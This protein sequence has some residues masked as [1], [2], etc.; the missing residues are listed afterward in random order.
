MFDLDK[1][2]P[3]KSKKDSFFIV[4]DA[5]RL[6]GNGKNNEA[7]RKLQFRKAKVCRL[8]KQ[9]SG[10]KARRLRNQKRIYENGLRI[11]KN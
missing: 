1:I 7:V 9:S 11:L 6:A 10:L 5:L 3:V 4:S 2:R 8:M